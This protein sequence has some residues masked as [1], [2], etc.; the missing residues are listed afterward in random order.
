MALFFM[1]VMEPNLLLGIIAVLVF[2]AAGAE[3]LESQAGTVLS[4]RRVGDAYN[5]YALTLSLNDRVS[6]VVDYLL[7]SYQPDFAVVNR[8]QL[9]GI[10]TRLDVARWLANNTY[11][12]FVTEIMEEPAKVLRVQ[13]E[14]SLDEVRHQLMESDRRVAAVYEHETYLGLCSLEHIS[15]AM[16]ILTF[17]DRAGGSGGQFST[18]RRV[19][20]PVTHSPQPM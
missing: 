6:N 10:V 2:F 15:E 4:T 11:D 20:E 13:A 8:G 16:A 7:K 9:Q 19:T 12:V 3:Q 5:R 18:A 14:Q 1:A 17:L